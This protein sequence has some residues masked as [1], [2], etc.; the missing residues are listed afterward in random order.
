[1]GISMALFLGKR[2]R[3][4]VDIELSVIAGVILPGMRGTEFAIIALEPAHGCV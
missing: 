4:R 3:A 1:M 2:C